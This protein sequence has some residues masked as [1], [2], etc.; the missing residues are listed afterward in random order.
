M[1]LEWQDLISGVERSSDGLVPAA[2]TPLPWQNVDSPQTTQ[3]TT[4]VSSPAPSVHLAASEIDSVGEAASTTPSV[5]RSNAAAPLEDGA[6][7]CHLCDYPCFIKAKGTRL[8][9]KQREEYWC[10]KCNGTNSSMGRGC[11]GWPTR[12]FKG[13]TKDQTIAFYRTKGS[14]AD[15]RFAYADTVAR[16]EIERQRSFRQREFRP[17]EYWVRL[18]YNGDSIEREAKPGDIDDSD[19]MVG[20]QYRVAWKG[21]VDDKEIFMERSE[22]LSKMKKGTTKRKMEAPPTEVGK[23]ED[24]DESDD[25]SS[26][27]GGNSK[28][29]KKRE[30]TS[31]PKG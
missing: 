24:Y 4:T 25:S 16:I 26:D 10:G 28:K 17:K 18:G 14:A 6:V 29:Q 13:F 22:I 9:S 11:D 15:F 8:R 31:T 1:S 5:V 20:I 23:E 7:M 2:S 19:P 30:E 27:D 12:E 3:V 21:D